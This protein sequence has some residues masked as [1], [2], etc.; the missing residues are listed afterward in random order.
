MTTKPMIKPDSAKFS[1]GP[2]RK[3]EGWEASLLQD[4]L[5][6]RSHRS[7]AAKERM[8]L[9]LTKIRDILTLPED[10][11]VAI[12]PA[13]DT[14]AFEAAMWSLLGPRPLDVFAWENFG[15]NWVKD[16]LDQL[17]LED[18]NSYTADYGDLPDLSKANANHDIIFTWNGT[19]SG[20]RVPNAD[21]IADNR[22]GLTLCDATSAVFAMELPWQKLDVTTFSWQKVLGGE[23]QHG[24]IILSPRA[25]RRLEEHTPSWPIP[26]LFQMTKNG[27]VNHKI[28]EANTI[29]TPS[30]L[31]VEDALAAL[32]WLEAMGGLDYALEKSQENLAVVQA[33]VDRT[34]WVDFLCN[35]PALQSCTSLCLKIT[36][37]DYQALSQERQSEIVDEIVAMLED[38]KVAYDFKAYRSAPAG[39]RIW[40]GATVEAS[41]I[42][43]LTDWL[44]WAYEEVMTEQLKQAS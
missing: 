11:K 41:D 28:F 31:C 3:F 26:I 5:V 29:N 13:S 6:G 40:G 4:A 30:M 44:E 21:W 20:V 7:K 33:W 17:P 24:I 16:A 12:M 27:K 19:T 37:S 25:L 36:S 38:E 10:Y 14:G 8:Q 22:E 35:D 39:F 2:T 32:N 9:L 1:S 34:S 42:E 43:I 23:A 15:M 18:V